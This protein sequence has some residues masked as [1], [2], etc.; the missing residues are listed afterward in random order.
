MPARFEE[1]EHM[2]EQLVVAGVGMMPFVA[3][4]TNVA[5]FAERAIHSAMDDAGIDV[6]LV[7]QAVASHVGGDSR[8]GERILARAGLTGIAISSVGSGMASGSAALF[9]ARQALLSGE[10]KCALAFG[11][12]EEPDAALC[13]E[14]GVLCNAEFEHI[15]RSMGIGDET[16]AQVAIRARAHAARNPYALQRDPES[17]ARELGT[18]AVAGRPRSSY[19]SQASRGA[20]AI[21]L[22]TRRFAAGHGMRDDVV[23]AA[24]VLEGEEPD[25]LPEGPLRT[26]STSTTRRAAERAYEAA[27][28]DP[29]DI[30]VAELHDCCVGNELL[31]CTQLGLCLPDEVDRFVRS[32]ATT[33]GGRIVVSPSGGLLS[34]GSAPGVTGLA[35]ICELTWQLRGEA[36]QRQVPAAR[37]GLQHNGGHR[38][39]VSVA[40]LRRK[41]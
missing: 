26:R 13:D 29:A 5:G 28:V 25:E 38:G 2:P 18:P 1:D 30:D 21:I 11:F 27:G 36:G 17:L 19:I 35:Q 6:E 16:F 34:L 23:L 40:I 14:V 10:A 4:C 7:D 12:E 9:H 33:H 20:A 32:G 3:P 31:I 37:I 41:D 8:R 24:Q 39:A 22:C 15:A